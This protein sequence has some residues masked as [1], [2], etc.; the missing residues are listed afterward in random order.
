MFGPRGVLRC[1]ATDTDDPTE[2]PRWGRIGKQT[3]E[4]S[5]RPL[6]VSRSTETIDDETSDATVDYIKRQ[7]AANKP[8]FCWFNTTR[9]H[10]FTHVRAELRDKP[11]LT[12]RT[13]YNDGMIEH[14][15]S[16]QGEKSS[17]PSTMPASR[18]TP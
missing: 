4:D 16:R 3:I 10:A 9:M 12:S 5:D 14:D 17:R 8:F 1:K 6:T 13:E 7:A 15:S 11:G 18:A 2:Q